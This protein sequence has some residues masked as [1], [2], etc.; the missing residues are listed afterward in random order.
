LGWR[1]PGTLAGL[2]G[3]FGFWVGLGIRAV[4]FPPAFLGKAIFRGREIGKAPKL[5]T[6]FQRPLADGSPKC[7]WFEKAFYHWMKWL[8][9]IGGLGTPFG[10]F[11]WDYCRDNRS[12]ICQIR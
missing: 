8:W 9:K 4:F 12:Q 2:S 6:V 10:I 11:L 5:G 7:R 3:I 1:A